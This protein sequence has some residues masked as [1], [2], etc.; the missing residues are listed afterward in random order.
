MTFTRW[1]MAREQATAQA[2]ACLAHVAWSNRAATFCAA[3]P[4][5][6]GSAWL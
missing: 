1:R 6:V 5:I 4:C 3:S 2:F